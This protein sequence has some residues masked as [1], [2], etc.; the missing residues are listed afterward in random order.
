MIAA[1]LGYYNGTWGLPKTVTRIIEGMG[2]LSYQRL[3]RLRLTTLL[4]RRMRG[5]LIETF[6]II[7]GFAN[8]GHNM[9]GTSLRSKRFRLVSEQRNTEEGDFR[10]WPREKWNESQKVKDGRGGGEGRNFLPSFLPH[11]LP[12]LLLTPL[13]SRSL[14]LVPRP[15]LLNR[16]ETLATQ[17]SLGRIQLIELVILMSLLIIH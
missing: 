13:F 7:N 2:L 15:F 12:A 3:Q 16:T 4:E 10:Y 5:D 11:S 1:V 8:Y 9:F 6:Q 17:A 14:T